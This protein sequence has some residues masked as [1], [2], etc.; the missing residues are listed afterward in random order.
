ME[1]GLEGVLLTR[2]HNKTIS[3][4]IPTDTGQPISLLSLRP[5]AKPVYEEKNTPR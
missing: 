3:M 1:M 2:I 4:G 5:H